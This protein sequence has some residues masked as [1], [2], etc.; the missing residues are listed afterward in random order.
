[1]FVTGRLAQ[2]LLDDAAPGALAV[3][4][5]TSA[6]PQPENTRF[7]VP[8]IDAPNVAGA[9][10]LGLVPGD[11]RTPDLSALKADVEA[12]RVSLL[13][14]LDPG[15]AG[16]VGDTSWIVAARTSG[17]LPVLVVQAVAKSD[18]AVA[19]DIVLPGSAWVEKHAA[20]TNATGQLQSTAKAVVPPGEARDDW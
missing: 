14:V 19:A 2:E 13:Y 3:G 1:M 4:W 8:E 6:K 20:Y 12:G 7:K 15:P 9:K 10:A 11:A 17:Q 16:S 5:T 18:L